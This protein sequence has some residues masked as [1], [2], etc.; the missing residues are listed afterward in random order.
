MST[1]YCHFL[2]AVGEP[3]CKRADNVTDSETL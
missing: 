3:L 2:I 1:T